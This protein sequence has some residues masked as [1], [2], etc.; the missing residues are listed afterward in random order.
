MFENHL[1]FVSD[2]LSTKVQPGNQWQVLCFQVS[3]MSRTQNYLI[4]DIQLTITTDF[5]IILTE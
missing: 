3:N 2:T 4:G 1:Y 5:R